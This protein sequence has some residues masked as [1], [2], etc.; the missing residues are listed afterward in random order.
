MKG[1]NKMKYN[2]A[3]NHYNQTLEMIIAK[4]IIFYGLV[5]NFVKKEKYNGIYFYIWIKSLVLQFW[6]CSKYK[7]G[8]SFVFQ[9]NSGNLPSVIGFVAVNCTAIGEKTL[10]ILIGTKLY[11]R[12]IN[13]CFFEF[14]YNKCP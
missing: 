1:S 10:F 9:H 14:V 4:A 3:F 12:S 2:L 13:A 5:D 7:R 8:S 11:T 6:Y